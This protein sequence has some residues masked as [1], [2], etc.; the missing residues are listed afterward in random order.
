[1]GTPEGV[2][3]EGGIIDFV[4]RVVEVECLPTHIPD[5]LDVDVSELHIN[6][7]VTVGE[8]VVGEGV[9]VLDDRDQIVAVVVA[10]RVEEVAAVEEEEAEAVEEEPEV[11]A[12][13]K[14]AE[15]AEEASDAEKQE[16]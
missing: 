11:A 5:H 12:K 14:E 1:V 9:E 4:N 16:G 10:P 13:G 7:N 8:L 15:G 6:Q 2:K 3:N